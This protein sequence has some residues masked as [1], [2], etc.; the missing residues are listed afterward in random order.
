[1]RLFRKINK[2]SIYKFCIPALAV[3]FVFSLSIHN[4]SIAG[5]SA[6]NLDT[7]PAQSHSIEDC[8]ACWLQKNLQVPQIEY[9]FNGDKLGELI[10]FIDTEFL[11]PTS[12]LNLDKPSRSPPT[13]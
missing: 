8:S 11:I 6:T 3:L 5:S 4:H 7:N 13:V 9:S 10:A 12:F 2:N 1:M